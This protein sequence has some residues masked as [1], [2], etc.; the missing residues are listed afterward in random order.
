MDSL[1]MVFSPFSIGN[2]RLKNRILMAAMGNNFSHPQGTV[3]DRA[4]AYYAERARGG[5]G[6]IITEAS[7]VSLSGRHRGRGLCAYDDSFLPG[8]RHLADTVHAHGSAMALQLHHAGR[9]AD[10][11]ISG[12]PPLAPSPIPRGPGWSSPKEMNLEEIQE[13]IH[14]FGSAARRAKEAG[15]DAVEVHGAHGYLI[16][17]FLSPRTNRRKDA[18]G[19]NPEK[20]L[21][22]ALEVLQ[23]VRHE[24]GEVFPVLFRLSAKEFIEN[25][26]NL[27]EALDWAV[28]LERAGS[29]ALHVS[30]GTTESLL[31]SAYVIPPMVFPE[32]YHVPLAAAIKKK[33]RIPVIA[34]GRLSTPEVAERVVCEGQA[35]LVAAG[36]AFLCDPHWPLKAAQG[37]KDR[38]RPCVACNHCVWRLF[39]QE[40]LS[41]FQN[42]LLGNE[43][44]YRVDLAEKAKKVV[45]I[46]GGPGGLEAARVAR[47][48]GHRVTLLEKNSRLGGQM[49]PAST[50]PHKQNLLKAVEWLTQEV[51]REGVDIRLNTEGHEEIIKGEKPDAV[52]VAT[53]ARP[54]IPDHFSAPNLL[55]AWDVFA[56]EETGNE[57][58]ILGGGM[59]GM[60]TAEFLSQKGCRVTVVEMLE[61]LAGDMEGTTRALLLE[62]LPNSK[63]SVMLSTKVEQVRD[64]KVLVS[65]AGRERWLEAQTIV[66]ALGSRANN[67]IVRVL[68]ERVPQLFVIGDCVEPRRA[69]EAIHE[70]FSAALQI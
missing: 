53:G 69:K 45:I 29:S 27:E 16:H 33:V 26:Y 57:V 46:G 11:E 22:F 58:L 10:P 19:G 68:A 70:G 44:R 56:G 13:V 67:E 28:E 39:Q 5:A 59:V 3:S 15:F 54:V 47:K 2:L 65:S 64:R 60:E 21:R 24:L 51:K 14:Q 66:L 42:A 49:L 50:P 31:G 32:A 6:L 4:I 61:K 34:V 1:G 43:E 41:C 23:R 9:L 63:I 52:I 17:Q 36:R 30:G 48:R 35:D 55:T 20:R 7:P 40:A 37:E 8:L 12:G 25:G 38:I 18:Y 62:R